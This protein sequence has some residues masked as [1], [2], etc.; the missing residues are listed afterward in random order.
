MGTAIKT[1]SGDFPGRNFIYLSSKD[2]DLT[3]LDEVLSVF[4]SHRP[5]AV[6]HFAAVS[7]GIQYSMKYPATMLRDN[8]LMNINV[9]EAARLLDV[10]KTAMTLSA[11]MYPV[12]ASLPL[13]EDEIHNGYPHETNYSYSFAKRLIDPSIKAYRA[14]YGINVI[15]LISNGI[16]GPNMNFRPGE[17]VMVGDLIRRFYEN[18]DNGQ[19]VT[20]WGDG[21]PLREYTYSEDLARA[22]MWGLDHYDDEQVLN[23][24]STEEVSVKDT[25]YM[26]ADAIG[27]SR[28]RVVFDTSKPA[29]IYKKGTDNSRFVNL[30]GF[31][32][33]DFKTGLN[34][35]VKWFVEN[36]DLKNTRV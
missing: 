30:S 3:K 35:T 12:S 7:G 11:G 25:A 6:L 21:S 34:A 28:N 22:F 19:N 20:I 14:E 26:I 9:L 31:S 4:G 1:I 27:V 16:F 10:K 23:A 32:Y 13:S 8:V 33:Q 17:A 18:K 24:G 36:Y 5:D 2:C 29:G 15:G